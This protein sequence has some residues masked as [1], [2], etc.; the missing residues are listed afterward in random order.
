MRPGLSVIGLLSIAA[1]LLW[2]LSDEN[3]TS[4]AIEFG[5]VHH[6]PSTTSSERRTEPTA[7][8]RVAVADPSESKTEPT[9]LSRPLPAHAVL[10][11]LRGRVIDARS[12][13]PLA[14][15]EIALSGS[16]DS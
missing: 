12:S 7:T 6:N 2:W 16:D 4:P 5:G 13:L 1:L 10:V 11:Q 8:E 3:A 15:A 9:A 14:G